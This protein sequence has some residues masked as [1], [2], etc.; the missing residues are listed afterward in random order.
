MT[1]NHPTT[2]NVYRHKVPFQFTESVLKGPVWFFF[3]FEICPKKMIRR[4]SPAEPHF[5]ILFPI[6][7]Q[8]DR[9]IFFRK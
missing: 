3:G 1:H 8:S 7:V 9:F 5:P 4:L 6:L 2:L